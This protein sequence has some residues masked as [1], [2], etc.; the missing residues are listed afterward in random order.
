M[1]L[2]YNKE[3]I[4]RP[5]GNRN[6]RNNVAVH[7]EMYSPHVFVSFLHFSLT[8]WYNQHSDKWQG[9][10]ECFCFQLNLFSVQLK[11]CELVFEVCR[12]VQEEDGSFVSFSFWMLN[13]SVPFYFA[14]RFR[15]N[16][17]DGS[18]RR[19]AISIVTLCSNAGYLTTQ[20]EGT[21]CHILLIC[22]QTVLEQNT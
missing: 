1:L 12:M 19:R 7:E 17:T 9:F 8:L 22:V 10:Y 3:S 14:H 4:H 13:V 16:G 6:S 2:D 15:N 5:N 20:T 11:C 21:C 18:C